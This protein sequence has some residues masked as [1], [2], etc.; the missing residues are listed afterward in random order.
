MKLNEYIKLTIQNYL[1]ENVST[2]TLNA[3]KAFGLSKNN[4]DNE[5]YVTLY[6]GGKEL[7]DILKQ[8]EIFFMTPSYDEALDYAKMRKGE[9]FEI[10]VNPE[11]VNWN[12]GS[13]EVEFD[14]GGIIRNNK[15]IPNNNNK[16]YLINP[17]NEI[18]NSYSDYQQ[19][20][21]E[22]FKWIERTLNYYMT[23]NKLSPNDS[24]NKLI[25]DIE[26]YENISYEDDENY[27]DFIEFAKSLKYTDN[28]KLSKD[29]S[30]LSL[31]DF[32]EAFYEI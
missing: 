32:N 24:Y 6:H 16:K 4:I 8:N 14:K 27:D 30:K 23:N 31:L 19:I 13:Y 5:G 15:I 10:K 21:D 9:V 29:L 26:Y 18:K 28:N 22:L 1:N 20:S 11:D 2:N 17:F 12:Q 25:S 7:P 3:M